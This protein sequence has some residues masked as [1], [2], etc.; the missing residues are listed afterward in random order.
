MKSYIV[1]SILILKSSI[2]QMYF[3]DQNKVLMEGILDKNVKF[4]SIL[5]NPK[6]FKIN[7]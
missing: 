6:L 2:V 5:I 1:P 4:I 7:N 3:Y